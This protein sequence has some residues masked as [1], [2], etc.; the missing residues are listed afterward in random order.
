MEF[1]PFIVG[2]IVDESHDV[3]TFR[4]VPK[5][6]PVPS[7]KPGNFFLLMLRGEDGKNIFRPYSAA[8]HP[9]EEN[10]GFCIKL[11]GTFTQLLW[12]LAEGDAISVAGP[13]GLFTLDNLD[14]E[15]VFIAG[16]VGITAIRGMALQTMNEGKNCSLF[17]SAKAVADLVYLEENRELEAKN[18]NFRLYPYVT[19]EEPPANWQ[20]FAGRISAQ[21][22][23][24]KLGSLQGK[25]FYICGSREMAGG[26]ANSLLEAGVP[27]SKIKKEEWG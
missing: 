25:T 19:R 15:R 14:E 12:K 4:L 9:D 6:E 13:Y 27:K 20:G 3:K 8:S 5:D 23:E 22:L 26:I 17:H 21:A 2:K 18:Q 24:E 11:S 16:G 7:Y 1:S 10:L